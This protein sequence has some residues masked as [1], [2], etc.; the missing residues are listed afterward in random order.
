M[1][2]VEAKNFSERWKN[3][4]YEKGEAQIF[5]IELLE[6]IFSVKNISDF[7][8]FEQQ[9]NGKFIDAVIPS[10]KV[11]I[12]QKSFGKNL[13]AAY[14]QAKSYDNELPFNKKSRWIVCSDFQTFE[15]HDMNNPKNVSS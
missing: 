6:K 3:H 13:S 15:V 4:G 14:E 7:I 8:F 10:S 11:L 1:N 12:E 9:I 2:E 5:W